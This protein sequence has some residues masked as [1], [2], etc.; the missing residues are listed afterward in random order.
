MKENFVTAA[1]PQGAP[2]DAALLQNEAMFKYSYGLF[3]LTARES[4]KD[5]GCI[6]NTSMQVTADPQRILI[7][8]NKANF[9]HDMI[10]RTGVFNVSILTEKAPFAL[11]RRF[12]FQ[13]GRE[14]DKFEGFEGCARS[15]NG[16]LHLTGEVSNAV[17]S[18]QVVAAVDCGSHTLFIAQV[19]EART[20]NDLPSATYAY[21]FA[22]IKPKPQ[23]QTPAPENK[24]LHHWVCR[25][26]GYVYEG[27][28]LP[29]DYVC[30]IC[31]HP[32]A[33]FDQI[34]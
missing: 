13:S 34:D 8:V 1:L 9:T 4:E 20:Q 33:D 12:G 22:H 16:L 17:I 10:L 27:E 2:V 11:F 31:K 21:Y 26:C 30:P 5:N 3:V 7:A 29:P 14:V 19:T 15:T 24:Q 6:I 25:I 18:G 23:P 28:T 32:A